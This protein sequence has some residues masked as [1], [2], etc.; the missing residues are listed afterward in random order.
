M[1]GAVGF[2]AAELV[3]QILSWDA[4]VVEPEA[5]VVDAVAAGLGSAVGQPHVLGGVAANAIANLNDEAVHAL[6]FSVDEELR[7]DGG[8]RAVQSHVA[9]EKLLRRLCGRVENEFLR[10]GVVVGHGLDL[11][12]VA[13]VSE[14]GEGET[15]ANLKLLQRIGV[16]VN[17]VLAAKMHQR[18]TKQRKVHTEF[19]S[20]VGRSVGQRV[21]GTEVGAR[22]AVTTQPQDT[23]KSAWGAKLTW[24]TNK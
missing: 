6:V 15:A 19:G 1:V 14:F 17:V 23:A 12:S 16:L 8:V 7:E 18:A 20:D 4:L 24:L 9:D 22:V 2:D 11:A 5:P 13:S 3:Q 21:D 10:L